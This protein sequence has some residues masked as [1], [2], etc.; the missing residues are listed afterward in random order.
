LAATEIFNI[1]EASS[2][3]IH[4]PYAAQYWKANALCIAL[5]YERRVAV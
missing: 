3:E 1:Q 5:Q 2:V 4:F